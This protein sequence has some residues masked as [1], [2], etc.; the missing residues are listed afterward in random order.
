MRILYWVFLLLG[1]SAWRGVLPAAP[2]TPRFETGRNPVLAGREGTRDEPSD[3]GP[4]SAPCCARAAATDSARS[5]PRT[6]NVRR[7][8]GGHW[9]GS[10]SI[11]GS[12]SGGVSSV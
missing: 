4:T 7:F 5:P 11:A 6:S 2:A 10:R 1:V 9:S 8:G 3:P 12:R